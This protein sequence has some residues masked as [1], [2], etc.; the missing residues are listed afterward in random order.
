M[1]I[2]G[3]AVRLALAVAILAWTAGGRYQVKVTIRRKG[4][5]IMSD[6]IDVIVGP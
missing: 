5:A 3:H 2:I 4:A 1:R 6:T